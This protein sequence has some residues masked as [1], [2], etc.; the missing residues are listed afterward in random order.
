[1]NLIKKL[2]L[3]LLLITRKFQNKKQ[4]YTKNQKYLYFEILISQFQ[5]W[6]NNKRN[7][8]DINLTSWHNHI[9]F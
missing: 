4:L 6:L 5:I 8:R 2:N 1:M 7:Y 9:I 3:I